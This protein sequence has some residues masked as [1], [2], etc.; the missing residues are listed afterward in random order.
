[1]EIP[2][3]CTR[4]PCPSVPLVARYSSLLD[5]LTIAHSSAHYSTLPSLLFPFRSPLL[6]LSGYIFIHQLLV[7]LVA[8]NVPQPDRET[9]QSERVGRHQNKSIGTGHLRKLTLSPPP[10]WHHP[11]VILS[12]CSIALEA[13][14]VVVR[15][16]LTDSTRRDSTHNR[17]VPLNGIGGSVNTRR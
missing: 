6:G 8:T 5:R 2:A 13:S 12:N 3:N 4:P 11:C 16:P 9:S 14:L 1:M 7:N 17:P 10:T 15:L